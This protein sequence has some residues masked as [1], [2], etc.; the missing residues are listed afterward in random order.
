MQFMSRRKNCILK[1][2]NTKNLL[3][4]RNDLIFKY[5]HRNKFKL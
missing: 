3:N 2:K 1:Y 4:K 5:R